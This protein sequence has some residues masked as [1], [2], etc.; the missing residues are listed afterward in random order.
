[1]NQERD[2]EELYHMADDVKLQGAKHWLI[3]ISCL[4]L[5]P[6]IYLIGRAVRLWLG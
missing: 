4:G 6:V 5:F 3:V 2:G 1:M